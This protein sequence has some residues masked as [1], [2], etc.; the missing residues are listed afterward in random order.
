MAI[1]RSIVTLSAALLILP[2]ACGN[3]DGDPVGNSGGTNSSDEA[4]VPELVCPDFVNDAY[5]EL[6]PF[7]VEK[8]SYSSPLVGA[9]N[10][11]SNGSLSYS[12]AL[13]I[14]PGRFAPNVRLVVNNGGFSVSGLSSYS[15]CSANLAKLEKSSDKKTV[16]S[17]ARC[18]SSKRIQS[19][20]LASIAFEVT[21]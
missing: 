17:D 4:P 21:L 12:I 9:F 18:R 7:V 15:H 2:L 16:R 8:A 10:V 6:A 11:S 1:A 14:P 5:P 13:Q 3:D 20:A 19:I